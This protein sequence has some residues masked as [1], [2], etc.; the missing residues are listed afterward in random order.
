MFVLYDL[1]YCEN[2]CLGYVYNCRDLKFGIFWNYVIE[3]FN[4]NN[5]DCLFWKEDMNEE[6]IKKWKVVFYILCILF[7]N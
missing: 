4:V 7:I 5:R 3:N 2:K 6:L 1:I